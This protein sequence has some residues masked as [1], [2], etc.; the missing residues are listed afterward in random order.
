MG[1]SASSGMAMTSLL[2]EMKANLAVS[3]TRSHPSCIC[4]AAGAPKVAETT[5]SK[6]VEPHRHADGER[7]HERPEQADGELGSKPGSAEPFAPC[8]RAA[9]C[10]T[11]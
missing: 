7:E 1:T 6:L 9:R 8:A 4:A 11:L 5:G 10:R 3:G 2:G